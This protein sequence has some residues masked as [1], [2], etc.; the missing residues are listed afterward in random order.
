MLFF[1]YFLLL[2][3]W[4]NSSGEEAMP[5]WWYWY[6]HISLRHWFPETFQPVGSFVDGWEMQIGQQNSVSMRELNSICGIFLPSAGDSS[7]T[8]AYKPIRVSQ[9]TEE[10]KRKT[11]ESH[12]CFWCSVLAKVSVGLTQPLMVPSAASPP[13][14][15]AVRHI[16]KRKRKKILTGTLNPKLVW[17]VGLQQYGAE[18]LSW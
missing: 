15:E 12:N 17:S 7:R 4:S 5:Q 1:A 10:N 11:F 16:L 14:R 2:P 13:H 9:E 3:P 8:L 6:M 18:R